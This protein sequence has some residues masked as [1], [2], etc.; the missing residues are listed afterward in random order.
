MADR[1]GNDGKM[2]VMHIIVDY[3]S[4]L[5]GLKAQKVSFFRNVQREQVGMLKRN[6]Y[7]PGLPL[8]FLREK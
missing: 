2:D 5:Y 8:D 1:S 3:N 4:V 7:F 6:V